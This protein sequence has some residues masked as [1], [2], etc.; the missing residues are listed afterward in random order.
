MSFRGVFPLDFISKQWKN[1]QI[2]QTSVDKSPRYRAQVIA[3]FFSVR[4]LNV[5]LRWE[6][7]EVQCHPDPGALRWKE[8]QGTHGHT[9]CWIWIRSLLASTVQN[10]AGIRQLCSWGLPA[11]PVALLHP[12]LKGNQH[13]FQKF[14]SQFSMFLSFRPFWSD[15]RGMGECM[16]CYRGR[17]E[18]LIS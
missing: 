7:E 10:V 5:L 15:T 6:L 17:E 13:I 2:I 16:F 11:T 18:G 12:L 14:H 9:G 1:P 3:S 8:R 4:K